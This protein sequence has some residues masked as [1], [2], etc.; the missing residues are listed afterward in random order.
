MCVVLIGK[1]T[2]YSLRITK[3]ELQKAK[4][5]PDRFLKVCRADF[6]KGV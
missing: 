4:I 1:I 3:F 5:K 6:S 2:K